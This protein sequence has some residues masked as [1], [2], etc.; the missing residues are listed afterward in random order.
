MS[1]IPG[2]GT[3]SPQS[4]RGRASGIPQ[5][6]TG[7]PSPGVKRSSAI[8]KVASP[9]LP[10]RNK[11]PGPSVSGLAAPRNMKKDTKE[12][13]ITAQSVDLPKTGVTPEYKHRDKVPIV[14]PAVRPK[15]RSYKPST[16]LDPS[17]Y[18]CSDIKGAS[19]MDMLCSGGALESDSQLCDS[20]SCDDLERTTKIIEDCVMKDRTSKSSFILDLPSAD[21]QALEKTLKVK[22]LV[23][24]LC[25]M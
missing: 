7:V 6:G 11:Q 23:C 14:I 24:L 18:S 13:R 9:R 15:D 8:P 4:G 1:R 20:G 25:G 2:L 16:K 17:P 5:P 19:S 21:K 12:D 3:R 22:I 10:A